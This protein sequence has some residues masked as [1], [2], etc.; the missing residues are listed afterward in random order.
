MGLAEAIVA[1][2]LVT[3]IGLLFKVNH[4]F[5]KDN[6]KRIAEHEKCLHDLDK[7]LSLLVTIH[8]I[9]S[10]KTYEKAVEE[11]SFSEEL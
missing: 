11:N 7:K 1:L 3:F 5:C 10:K 4:D 8:K 2:G 9:K 6:K